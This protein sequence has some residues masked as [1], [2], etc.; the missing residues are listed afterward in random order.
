[1]LRTGFCNHNIL[2]LIIAGTTIV[3][4]VLFLSV[5]IFLITVLS[6]TDEHLELFIFS[7]K[8]NH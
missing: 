1:M 8:L 6:E 2:L 4:M 3:V 5:A 7:V